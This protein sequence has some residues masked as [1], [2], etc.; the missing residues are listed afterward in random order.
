MT[1]KCSN[2]NYASYSQ[3]PRSSLVKETLEILWSN[4]FPRSENWPHR[5]EV[6]CSV[7]PQDQ[8]RQS[9]SGRSSPTHSG[10]FSTLHSTPAA[11][12]IGH[13]SPE[14][15]L[16]HPSIN[17]PNRNELGSNILCA[18]V[19]TAQP[20]SSSLPLLS[21]FSSDKA[22]FGGW[23]EKNLQMFLISFPLFISSLIHKNAVSSYLFKNKTNNKKDCFFL[24]HCLIFLYF[25][26]Q[27]DFDGVWSQPGWFP[28]QGVGWGVGGKRH[29]KRAHV[30]KG[31]ES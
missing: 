31:S 25:V 15:H 6:T 5:R 22:K 8:K 1:W 30:G 12:S 20:V 17:T 23:W 21:G 29:M 10:S 11:L 3:N 16:H 4:S 19:G 18:A 14:K 28:G 13:G 26:I 27:R 2:W 7:W 24:C 9:G